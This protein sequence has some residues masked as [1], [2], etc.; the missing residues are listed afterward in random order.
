MKTKSTRS[1]I[2]NF[3][4]AIGIV[5][6]LLVSPIPGPE[7]RVSAQPIPSVP[8]NVGIIIDEGYPGSSIDS[9][10]FVSL[11]RVL[12]F[13][14]LP[15]E[16][17]DVSDG[18]DLT[19]QDGDGNPLFSTLVIMAPG[20]R[21]NTAQSES[22]VSVATDP[23]VGTGLVSLGTN[24][25][26]QILAPLFGIDALGN[27]SVW[28]PS[29]GVVFGDENGFTL[30]YSEET[31]NQPGIGFIDHT[32]NEGAAIV[33]THITSE[34]PAIW[35][36][37]N[38]NGAN[39]VF[40]NENG[41]NAWYMQGLLL[42]SILYTMPVGL[43][44]PVNAGAIQI[45]DSPRSYYS[46]EGL[47]STHYDFISNFLKFI[48]AYN[49]GASAF[50]SFSYS[51]DIDSF[52]AYPQSVEGVY[53]YLAAG[54]EIGLHCGTIHMPLALGDLYPWLGQEG[55]NAEVTAIMAAFDELSAQLLEEYDVVFSPSDILS[56]V[57][58][59][60]NI[61]S[62]GYQ[63]IDTLT[64]IKY[65]STEFSLDE[66]T[67]GGGTGVISPE[68]PSGF[69]V[70]WRDFGFEEGTLLYNLPRSQANFAVFAPN[71]DPA[72]RTAA[73]ANLQCLIES[74]QPY[75][76]FSHPDE[77]VIMLPNT[78]MDQV[79]MGYTAFADFVVQYPFYRW[80]KTAELGGILDARAPTL[81]A[82]WLP[83]S[84]T[85]EIMD[86]VAAEALQ[87]KT[88]F[89]LTEVALDGT[90]LS[91]T[92]GDTD[93]GYNAPAAYDIVKTGNNF[94][95][96]QNG[97]VENMPTTPSAP[98][99][100]EYSAAPV[101]ETDS[102]TNIEETT[103]VLN[104]TLSSLGSG[105]SVDVHFEWGLTPSFENSI[106]A[107]S[108]PMTATGSFSAAI[109][110]LESG[111][112]YFY[113]AVAS[114]EGLSIGATVSF[115]TGG[116][117]KTTITGV[118]Y[119]FG[120]SVPIA[121][122]TI[123]VND[124]VQTNLTDENG[125]YTVNVAPPVSP[126]TYTIG[127][128]KTGYQTE[129]QTVEVVI[130]NYYVVDFTGVHA[131]SA[132]APPAVAQSH[133]NQT[134]QYG[135]DA[136]FTATATGVPAL[137]AQWQVSADSGANWATVGLGVNT[138]LSADRGTVTTLT[139]TKPTVDMTGNQYRVIFSNTSGD[140]A[141]TAAASLT[142]EPRPITVT[143]DAQ[144]KIYGN[145]DPE[146]TYK[147]TVGVL[148]TGDS[149][150]GGLLRD[151]GELVGTYAIQQ[152]DLNELSGNYA[153][154]YVGADLTIVQ[155]PLTVIG[156]TAEN[157]EYD[158][159]TDAVINT[160]SA[161]LGGVITGDSGNVTLTIEAP[162]GVFENKNAGM[163]KAVLVSGMSIEGSAIGNYVLNQ[164]TATADITAKE[165]TVDGTFTA[166]NK[167]YDG[168]IMAVVADNQ[169]TLVGILDGE[170]V[171]LSAV[172]SFADANASTTP[173][174]V[175]LTSDSN[176]GG[177]DGGNYVL[178]FIDAPTTTA[179]ITPAT[180][181]PTVTVEDKIFDG[182]TA[183]TIL[184]R[185]LSGVIG[186][187]VVSLTGGTAAFDT[188]DVGNDKTVSVTGL[189]LSGGAAG[190]YILSS[191]STMTTADIT[192][193]EYQTDLE[194]VEGWNFI[195][196]P[197]TPASTAIGDVL[198]SINDKVV[199]VWAYDG[200]EWFFY[201][202]GSQFSTLAQ[203]NVGHG[204][205]VNLNAQATLTITGTPQAVSAIELGTGWN[206]VSLPSA[207]SNPAID[208]VLSGI[209]GG[210]VSVWCYDGV[211][212]TW[213]FFIPDSVFSTLTEMT[214]GK[215]YWVNMSASGT[216]NIS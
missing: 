187:D 25:V 32:V 165:L 193:T 62:A 191:N 170:I 117:P 113:R 53:Q 91:L 44:S 181:M 112:N 180:V 50:I 216:L 185:T 108:S 111:T 11:E 192:P 127:V 43:G 171:T 106:I 98:F 8:I 173:K 139:I 82:R 169:L 102:V 144:T 104:G 105:D 40:F 100:F 214:Q 119:E 45:D 103:A 89:F 183:A 29:S 74:G 136:I 46:P 186:D 97:A 184:T 164:P 166:E 10:L 116:T 26:N 99:V 48:E 42:Q 199:S 49:L 23:V 70:T 76:I 152:G 107:E 167:I 129:S 88:S 146:Y 135:S 30:S 114:A 175:S 47:Q 123:T 101:V 92:F 75:L 162:V 142:V 151:E 204:Y 27:E 15:W 65:V 13:N 96:Y 33:A 20:F 168:S 37:D 134:V 16:T 140:D 163:D 79:F 84:S 115:V 130:T 90:T 55:L 56:Y 73:F 71:T 126:Y 124:E 1:K 172:V 203:M 110:G 178:S 60:N 78:T 109:S 174:P 5:F 69:P 160:A 95:I 156:I 83:G 64:D 52:W 22:I 159:N 211:T 72:S 141:V 197:L 77:N 213:T 161:A 153:L 155:R 147:V 21:I 157:K 2:V 128:S 18:Q 17:L 133:E 121:G 93:T 86:Y 4:L 176:L 118:V 158:G 177:A 194:L 41:M 195:G 3:L 138:V 12:E 80:L 61:D 36:Y 122:A 154:T 132:L 196:L 189:T 148:V 215:S 58:A 39:T 120:G 35:T 85:L 149:L 143:A 57:A 206:L 7:G 209:I 137:T 81:N 67:R 205:W 188:P 87:V 150:S 28:L 34:K 207:P 201:I 19:L 66:G 210:V 145:D 190:N 6:G 125:R 179:N 38:S 182:T 54:V 14:R 31:I 51:Y 212:N 63:A 68:Y 131:L 202:P 208:T 24:F 9:D 200:T 198:M 59:S 94:F